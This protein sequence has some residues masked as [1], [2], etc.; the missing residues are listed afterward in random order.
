MRVF[1]KCVY[2]RQ[3]QFAISVL[4]NKAQKLGFL[5]VHTFVSLYQTA[6]APTDILRFFWRIKNLPSKVIYSLARIIQYLQLKNN[7][8][9]VISMSPFQG[10][11][12]VGGAV[13]KEAASSEELMSWF[14]IGSSQRHVASTKMNSES[15]R[16]HLVL[17]IIIESTNLTSGAVVKGKVKFYTHFKY[18]MIK[19]FFTR[20]LKKQNVSSYPQQIVYA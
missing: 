15:S 13:V 4:S 3:F 7:R 1:P 17:S 20:R 19:T 18:N 14:E 6:F 5:S 2:F 8:F 12:V 16:S 10:M 9:T 11:V